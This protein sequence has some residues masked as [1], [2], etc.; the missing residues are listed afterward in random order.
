[1]NFTVIID[2]RAIQDV[3]KVLITMKN[4]K[5]GLVKSLKKTLTNI[6]LNWKQTL[7]LLCV[8]TT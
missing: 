2:P 3:Q 5:S 7:F 8:M 4:N 6:Y 1:M